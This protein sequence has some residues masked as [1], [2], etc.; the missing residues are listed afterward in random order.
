MNEVSTVTTTVLG[1]VTIATVGTDDGTN[2][3]GITT[4]LGDPGTVMMTDDGTTVTTKSAGTITGLTT[5]GG[6]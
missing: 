4:M 5:V 6:T 2:S 3:Y 1:K